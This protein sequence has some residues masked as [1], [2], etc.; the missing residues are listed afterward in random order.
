MTASYFIVHHIC[1]LL[2]ALLSRFLP[3]VKNSCID[4][5]NMGLFMGLGGNETHGIT[6]MLSIYVQLRVFIVFLEFLCKEHLTGVWPCVLHV[7]DQNIRSAALWWTERMPG[8]FDMTVSVQ[9]GYL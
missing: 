9:K 6:Q 3:H 1:C 2:M 5:A 4:D 7:L 8:G